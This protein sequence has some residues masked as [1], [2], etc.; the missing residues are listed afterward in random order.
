MQ[1]DV[2]STSPYSGNPV[3]VVLDGADLSDEEME[4]LARWTNLSE[5]TFVLPSTVPEAD[6]RLRIFTPGGE[7][8]FAGHPTLGSA[9]AW[10]DGGGTPQHA[11]YLVQECAAGLVTVRRGEDWLC[12]RERTADVHHFRRHHGRRLFDSRFRPHGPIGRVGTLHRPVRVA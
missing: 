12:S 10:L 4:R 2:F 1:V 11:E 6:Y 5:T 7:L 3:A 8:P 9:R